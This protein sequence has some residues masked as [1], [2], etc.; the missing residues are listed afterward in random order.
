MGLRKIKLIYIIMIVL[1]IISFIFSIGIGAVYIRPL[2]SLGIIADACGFNTYIAYE[3]QQA[4]VLMSI[5][6]P[7]VLLAVLIGAGLGISGASMQGLF[8][9]PLADPSLIGISSG[10]SLAAVA[11]I[12]V[13]VSMSATLTGL[14]GVYALAVVTFLG[15]LVTAIVVYRLSQV[16]GRTVISMMLLTGI[17]INALTSAFTGFFT[18]SANEAQLRSI[19]F[20]SLG[21]LGGATWNNVV[22]LIPFILL[23][24]IIL[25]FFAKQLNTFALGENGAA[26]LGVNTE[27]VKR[28][29]VILTALCVGSSVAVA[30]VIVFIGLIVPHVMRLIAGPDHRY[31]LVL[32]ALFGA[33]LLLNA[34]LFSRVAQAPSELPISIITGIIGAPVFLYL[35]LKERKAQRLA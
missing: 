32:S 10:A 22:G 2:Q 30:G 31:L 26:H 33:V 6:L 18:Y 13:G 1:L 15:A 14:L 21:S 19:V 25:P 20:W 16:S 7:R 5:R 3:Q 24:V 11:F 17:A 34:D 12:V 4:S 23:P 9:N 8:R 27:K 35:L 29:I 28:I